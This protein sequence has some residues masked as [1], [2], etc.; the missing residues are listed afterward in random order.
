MV[1]GDGRRRRAAR[2]LEQ[3]LAD[4][5]TKGLPRLGRRGARNRLRPPSG[6]RTCPPQ[7]GGPVSGIRPW[8]RRRD[9]SRSAPLGRTTGSNGQDPCWLL[10]IELL[11]LW[12]RTTD[13]QKTT[14]Q[15]RP[16]RS[17]SAWSARAGG[18]GARRR[19]EPRHGTTSARRRGSWTRRSTRTALRPEP[20]ANGLQLLTQPSTTPAKVSR[21][22][23]T[24][25]RAPGRGTEPHQTAP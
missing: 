14:L 23:R 10:R 5:F 4:A 7:W 25:T 13:C 20:G 11:Q 3:S 22:Q 19:V 18:R 12:N 21:Q 24:S 16:R 17:C 8:S 2:R 15:L 9:T 6:A 1:G